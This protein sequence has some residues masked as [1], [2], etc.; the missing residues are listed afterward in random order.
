MNVMGL[1]TTTQNFW[2][3]TEVEVLKTASLL[4]IIIYSYWLY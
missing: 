2:L 4:F 1:L 3:G